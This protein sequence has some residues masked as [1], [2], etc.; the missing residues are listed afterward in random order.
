MLTEAG[1]VPLAVVVAPANRHDTKLLEQTLEAIVVERPNPIK[2][3]PQHLCLDKA[4]D[5]PAGKRRWSS[6]AIL[7]TSAASVKSSWIGNARRD[8]QHGAGQ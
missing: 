6:T 5:N 7:V 3:T 4:Y 2:K 8:L 1:G